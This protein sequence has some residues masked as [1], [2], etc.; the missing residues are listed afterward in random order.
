MDDYNEMGRSK[1][2]VYRLKKKQTIIT[3]DF[4]EHTINYGGKIGSKDE[5]YQGGPYKNLLPEMHPSNLGTKPGCI[6]FYINAAWNQEF[7]GEII[8]GR[9]QPL[10][11]WGEPPIFC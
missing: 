1:R 10:T 3:H 8:P 5:S 4:K 2:I 7:V 9:V 6:T 11:F